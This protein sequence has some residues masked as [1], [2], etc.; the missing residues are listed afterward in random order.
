MIVLDPDVET[1]GEPVVFPVKLAV[2]TD[3]T[4]VPSPP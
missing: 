2:G 3:R 1:V 4:T